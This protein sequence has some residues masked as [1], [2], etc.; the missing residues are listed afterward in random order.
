VFLALALLEK[1]DHLEARVVLDEAR[2]GAPGSTRDLV[3]VAEAALL[4]RDHQPERALSLLRSLRGRI[5]DPDERM[6]HGEVL[7]AAA[8][9][10]R[11]YGE[12]V[13]ALSDMLAEAP[14]ER[15]PRVEALVEETLDRLPDDALERGLAALATERGD[16][17][18]AKAASFVRNRLRQRLA[19]RA[20]ATEDAE[21]AARL[22]S[23]MPSGVVE[24][25]QGAELAR[26]AARG[27]LQP[28]VLGRSLGLVLS[29]HDAAARTRSAA[30][31]AGVSRALA[32]RGADAAAVRLLLEEEGA[33]GESDMASAL[34]KLAADGA[35]VL[36][37]AVEPAAAARAARFAESATIPVILL[38][39]LA[40]PPG[41]FSFALGADAEAHAAELAR[42][43]ESRG[44]SRV[45]IVGTRELPCDVRAQAAFEPRFPVNEWRRTKTEAVMLLGDQACSLSVVR[46]LERAG[47]RPLLAFG[48]ESARLAGTIDQ[49]WPRLV[50]TV[51]GYPLSGDKDASADDWYSVL[52]QEA[53]VLATAA[54]QD[55][56]DEVAEA[57]DR[58]HELHRKARDGLA[59]AYA[60]L[61]PKHDSAAGHAQVVQRSLDPVFLPRSNTP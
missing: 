5:V 13:L 56:P 60:K 9:A 30:A 14:L 2:A 32:R 52:G 25:E 28:R 55:L 53:A 44:T 12:A 42:A 46:E 6:L 24:R 34:A 1:G 51:D 35:A 26:L 54:L 59:R 40:E 45:A 33:H 22:V 31:S 8:A 11:S 58:V 50:V 20:L 7:L 36:V 18:R 21:L 61:Y 23:S 37:A 27:K 43:L 17:S 15:R 38:S 39:S 29:M 41:P 4:V 49:R 57:S 19:L 3:T 16:A 48:L 47:L 10:G